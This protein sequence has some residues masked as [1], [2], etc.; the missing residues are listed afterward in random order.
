MTGIV[1]RWS[2]CLLTAEYKQCPLCDL[3]VLLIYV[4]SKLKKSICPNFKLYHYCAYREI[5]TY[6]VH[7]K[8]IRNP[9]VVCSIGIQCKRL[10][11]YPHLPETCDNAQIYQLIYPQ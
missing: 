3:K 6:W 8:W 10:L 4:S 1:A 2:N 9:A 5:N 11:C 7:A